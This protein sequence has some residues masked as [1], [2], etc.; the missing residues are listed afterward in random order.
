MKTNK[1]HKD[2]KTKYFKIINGKRVYFNPTQDLL[3]KDKLNDVITLPAK[4]WI[5]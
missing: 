4:S 1:K 5:Y 3:L 2:S